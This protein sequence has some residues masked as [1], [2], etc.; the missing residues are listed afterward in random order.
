MHRRRLA[1]LVLLALATT[2]F[3]PGAVSSAGAQDRN[4]V[5]KQ[6]VLASYSV[7]DASGCVT[8]S[9]YVSADTGSAS[10]YPTPEPSG[11]GAQVAITRFDTCSNT[12]LLTASGSVPL[13]GD[14][15]TL[16]GTTKG[17]RLLVV[18]L[19]SA[20]ATGARSEMRVDL[21]WRGVGPVQRSVGSPAPP[22]AN[23]PRV[24]TSY[25]EATLTG[26]V[27]DGTD[28]FAPGPAAVASITTAVSRPE[29]SRSRRSHADAP[30]VGGE[31]AAA[32][33]SDAAPW[34]DPSSDRVCPD[35]DLVAQTE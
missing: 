28:A 21:T 24:R 26:T 34:S 32:L 25:R 10:A 8:T 12:M 19:V 17:A 16:T 3:A 6:S 14:E 4:V 30:T 7:P 23:A 13:Q 27:T 35:G 2:P 1:I 18:I 29:G 33:F 31:R 15:L 20:V 5:V 11:P 22:R 9:V